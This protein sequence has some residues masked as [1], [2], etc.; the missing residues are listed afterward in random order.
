MLTNKQKEFLD[1]ICSE[2]KAGY[3]YIFGVNKRSD[4]YLVIGLTRYFQTWFTNSKLVDVVEYIQKGTGE[5][6]IVEIH[7]GFKYADE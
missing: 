1:A 7:A 4:L 6:V 5:R 3:K 2:H